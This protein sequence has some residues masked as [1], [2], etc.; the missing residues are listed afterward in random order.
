MIKKVQYLLFRKER[1][2]KGAAILT[3]TTF[4]SY[5]TGLLRDR[6]LARTFGAGRELDLYNAS[7]VVPDL[8]FNILIASTLSAAF[9]PI[10]TGMLS[11]GDQEKA[12]DLAN[13]VLHAALMVMVVAA[14]AAAVFM[15]VFVKFFTKDSLE[16][17]QYKLL[18]S[19][20]RLMLISPIIMTISNTLGAVLIGF[21]RFL[22]YGLS[23]ILY[24]IGILIGIFT[25]KWF[26]IYGLVFGTLIGALLHTIPRVV[27]IAHSRFRYKTVCNFLNGDFR[28]VVKLGLPK[29]LGHPVEQLTFLAFTR[30]ALVG[31]TAGSAAVVSFAR[32]FQSVPVALFGIAFSVAIFPILSECAAKKD[33][34]DFLKN[35]WKALRDILLFTIP[36]SLGLYVLS[37]IPI[38]IFLGGGKFSDE[39]ILRTAS[40]LSIFAFSIPTESLVHLLAR[41]FYALKNTLI[42]VLLSILGLVIAVSFASLKAPVIGIIAIPYGFFLG[43]FTEVV[44]LSLFLRRKIKKSFHRPSSLIPHL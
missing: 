20:S 2:T 18:I 30:I 13:T 39:N 33:Q 37:E 32:N 8:L 12:N 44:L 42:P 38:R 25:V 36:A 43:S 22:P 19:I 41:S 31:L 21:K 17:P 1:F 3:L 6:I 9:I 35:F 11:K 29:M 10:F 24:N 16:P 26:G 4:G 28:R 27:S 14:I 34:Q 40:V 5:L 7:F 23:P 15:P